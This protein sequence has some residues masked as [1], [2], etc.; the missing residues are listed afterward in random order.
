MLKIKQDESSWKLGLAMLKTFPKRLLWWQKVHSRLFA[1]IVLD[2]IKSKIPRGKHPEWDSYVDSLVI[3]EEKAPAGKVVIVLEADPHKRKLAEQDVSCTVVYV[4]VRRGQKL[5][6]VTKLL[7]KHGPWTIDTI[8]A[9]PGPDADVEYK[10][11]SKS[12]ATYIRQQAQLKLPAIQPLLMKYGVQKPTQIDVGQV[13]AVQDIALLA[14]RLEYGL[15]GQPHVPH[16]RAALDRLRKTWFQSAKNAKKA[17]T[18][19]TDPKNTTWQTE[20]SKLPVVAR[21]RHLKYDGFKRKIR[22]SK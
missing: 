8:P 16:L 11:V 20:P 7:V 18:T 9:L 1:K 3:K 6:A 5:T 15:A 17:F 19:I 4:H 14:L 2:A 22:G 12:E 21:G 10:N 13:D